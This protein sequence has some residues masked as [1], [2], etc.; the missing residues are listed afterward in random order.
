[1]LT[2]QQKFLLKFVVDLL[3][4]FCPQPNAETLQITCIFF[5]NEFDN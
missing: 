3:N 5:Q 4:H 2:G 1:M